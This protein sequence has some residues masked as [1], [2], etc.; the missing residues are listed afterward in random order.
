VEASSWFFAR[1]KI[2]SQMMQRQS[3]F[4]NCKPIVIV[5][6]IKIKIKIKIKK[7]VKKIKKIAMATV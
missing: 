2:G 1:G 3:A 6:V 4:T 7:I 5:I